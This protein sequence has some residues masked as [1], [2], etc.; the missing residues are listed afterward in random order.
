MRVLTSAKVSCVFFLLAS[1][2]STCRDCTVDCRAAVSATLIDVNDGEGRGGDGRRG[3][4]REE[5]RGG[6]ERGGERG[7]REGEGR[8]GEEMK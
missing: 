3:R 1:S 8:G 2:N 7:G 4:G 6:R 5:G